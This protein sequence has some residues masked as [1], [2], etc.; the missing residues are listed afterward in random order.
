MLFNAK[1]IITSLVNN[2][3]KCDISAKKIIHI[4]SLLHEPN[5]SFTCKIYDNDKIVFNIGNGKDESL[6]QDSSSDFYYIKANEIIEEVVPMLIQR[7]VIRCAIHKHLEQEICL[8]DQKTK[9]LTLFLIDNIESY[10]QIN[11]KGQ[12]MPGKYVRIFE[13]EYLKEITKP[14]YKTLP[15]SYPERI[16][17]TYDGYF[18]IDGKGSWTKSHKTNNENTER[19]YNLI[20]LYKEEFSNFSHPVRFIFSYTEL[21]EYW[22]S[23]RAL[24]LF[25]NLYNIENKRYRLVFNESALIQ[26]F[27]QSLSRMKPV[28]KMIYLLRLSTITLQV[29]LFTLWK[30]FYLNLSAL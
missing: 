3:K 16:Q 28:E 12:Y 14:A 17:E 6:T 10:R 19:G 27:S 29:S 23:P 30:S 4:L 20:L 26:S 1:R 2:L 25:C 7:Y 22:N 21:K 15:H 11:E 9:V 5:M 24:H 18:S 8:N 13:E